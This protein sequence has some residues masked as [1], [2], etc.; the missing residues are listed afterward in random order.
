MNRPLSRPPDPVGSWPLGASTRLMFNLPMKSRLFSILAAVLVCG[1]TLYAG[2]RDTLWKQVD[3]AI[4]KGLPQTAIT[5]LN[6]ILPAALKAKAY[7][8]AAKA[9]LRRA[10]LEGT[11]QGNKPEEKITRLEAELV[12]APAEIQPLLASIQAHWYWHYFQQ[13]RWRFMNRTQTATAPG[14]D[15]TTWDLPR[16]FA[17]IDRQFQRSL[18]NAARLQAIPMTQFE[19]ILQKGT[20]P[21][22]YRPTLYDFL[23]H[24]AL[25]FYMAGEQA[26]A[27]PED[28][29]DFMADRPV[30]GVVRLF[31][32]EEEFLAGRIER[33]AG[34]SNP[35][36]ALFLFRDLL[37]F[38]ARDQDPTARAH[39]D[40]AR[41]RWAWN[42][43]TGD[44]KPDLYKAALKRFV[45]QWADH[46][47]AAEA[48]HDWARVLRGED[49]LVEA[50]RLAVRG[51]EAHPTSVGGRLCQNLVREIEA[52][53]LNVSTER[54]WNKPWPKITVQY[55]NLTNLHF[56]VVAFDWHLFL[57][58]NH[59]RPENLN[60]KDR[61]A[62]LAKAPVLEWSSPL[63]ATPDFQ[64]RTVELP[65]PEKLGAGFYFLLASAKPGF[66][67]ADN[68]VVCADFWVSELALVVRANSGQTEGFVL[69]AGSGEPVAGAE[70]VAWHLDNNG[71]R[72]KHEPVR[73]DELGLFKIPPTDRPRGLLLRARHQ[74]RELATRQEYASWNRG[75]RQSTRVHR[76][77]I[78]FTDRALYR[79]GQTVQYKGICI[80][81]QQSSDKYEVMPGA[82]LTVL[83]AD[84]NGKEIARQKHRANDYGSFSGSFTAPR[85]R[86]MGQMHLRIENGPPGSGHFRVE[87]YKRPKFQVT[88]EAPKTAPRLDDRVSVSGKA[89]AYT[90]AA[91]DGATVKWRVVREVRWPVWW[92]WWGG[93]YPWRG[94]E[95]QE[96]AHGTVKTATDGAFKVEFLARP[97][98]SISPTNEPTFQFTV[99]ADVTDPSGETRSADRSVRVGYTAL[100]ASVDAESWQLAGTPVKMA[101]RTTTLDGEGQQAEG[102]LK[103]HR[104]KEPASVVRPPLAGGSPVP[105]RGM[106]VQEG[107]RAVDLSDPNQWDLGEVA[108]EKGFNTDAEGRAE[109]QTPLA[110]G[111]YRVMLETQDRFGKKV[112]A[113]LPLRVL[114]PEEPKLS[115]KIPHLFEAPKWQ[116][117]PGEEFMAVWGTGY[118]DG[119]AFVEIEHRGKTIQRFWTQPGRTQQQVK[120]AVTEAMRG[121]FNVFV[122]QV[123][124][125][126][127]YLQTRRV[128][129]PWSNKNL[130]L[131]WEHFVSKLQPGQKETWSLS[132]RKPAV[133][134]RDQAAERAVAE[135]VAGLYDASL[136][137]FQKHRW[138]GG[139]SVFRH[140]QSWMTAQFE[141]Q[142]LGLQWIRGQWGPD[143]PGVEVTYRQFPP[144]LVMN[145]WGYGF[146]SKGMRAQSLNF[147]TRGAVLD[148][149]MPMPAA[150]APAPLMEAADAMAVE[151]TSRYGLAAR[152]K[153]GVAEIAG[154]A[155]AP[156][157][158]SGGA[159][160]GAGGAVNLAQVTARKNLNETAFFYP[161]VLSDSN[162]VVKLTFT[163]PEA[164]TTWR[165][166]AFAHD[167]EL[168]AGLIEADA[169][170]A[171]DL[172]VQ[173][174][175]PRFLREGDTLEFSVKVSNQSTNRQT[176]KV[177]LEL[178][179]A[180]NDAPADK[181]LKLAGLVSSGRTGATELDFDIPAKESRTFAWRLEVP[182]GCGFLAYKAVGATARMSDGEEGWL[183]VLSRRILVTESLPLPIRGKVG[184]GEVVKKFELEKL[185]KSGR[186]STLRHQSYT[187]QMVSQPAWYAVMALPCLMEFPHECSE[188][189][190]NRFYA[191]ALARH[192]ALK[193]PKI[194]RVFDQWKGTAALDS[195][196]EKNQDLKAVMLEETPWARQAQKEGEGRRNVGVLFDE[197]RLTHEQAGTLRKLVEMQ[198]GDGL[199][200]W[201]PGGRGNDY[202]TLYIVTGFG[203]LRHL[204]L[205][206]DVG[207]ALKALNRLDTWMEER[208]REIKK[209]TKP[210]DYV[211]GPTE[212]LFLY[213]RSFFLKD[214]ALAGG[215][216]EAV[217]FFRARAREHWLKVAN[218]Q[219]QGHL[220][221]ALDRFGSQAN[222]E[223][224]QA[225]VRSLKERSVRQ[226]EMGMF[227][228]ETELSWWWYR[229]PIETQAMMIEVFDEV[230]GDRDAVEECRVWLLKQ[231][232]T[233]D[234][235]TTKATADAVYALLLR[236]GNLL[237]S[238]K[239][240]EVKVGGINV[241]PG[242]ARTEG[243]TQPEA[244][245]G[246]YERRFGPGEIKP[247]MGEITVR[248]VDEGVSWG[249]VHWQY[250]EDMTKVTPYEGTPLKLKKALY[251]RVNTAKGPTLEPVKGALGVG[252]EL[253]VR[254]ELRVD[255]DMEYVH[256]KDQRGSGTEPVNVL[257]TYRYQDGL[258][259]YESTRDTASHFF[260]DYLP[261]GT[262]VF[263]YASRVQH[264][265]Q[266]QT[267]MASIQCMYAPEFNS[268]S[269][270]HALVVK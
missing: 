57:E 160:A 121:G 72:V 51:A 3:E 70:V 102:K 162:G 164:L 195:P 268:H 226:E 104:L 248:K 176:G 36:K 68:Q 123:R 147:R 165:L 31:G 111:L 2:G 18:T 240:V 6:E 167:K 60:D 30:A 148:G 201:F 204:G 64:E 10:M 38:H 52:R 114:K 251:R 85:D 205:D 119:R 100:E 170:T 135:L 62:V 152:A 255:R 220:A 139:F 84:V 55:R 22:R 169:V 58:K 161:Q 108:F 200:P 190:F 131:K 227:W 94:Q 237:A 202:I 225:I 56:R 193:D 269:E 196:L 230:A 175:P 270:S 124:E 65:A 90:G 25:S 233:Q 46:E 5:N 73:S 53:A 19:D 211:P 69:E 24:E 133:P 181:D 132:I 17:E 208:Y 186:S 144:D 96:I 8:E 221:L 77:T 82:D 99:H 243:S 26:A 140:D 173:P 93:R 232:Q 20:M 47:I 250:L 61:A 153:A 191:N 179:Y 14:K 118:A 136:D 1:M 219:N 15:F 245:T 86:L 16:L 247:A 81:F 142:Q 260:I 13:N 83:F 54:V 88:L 218:R 129:V 122:T 236:G 120:L 113:R 187:V 154:V 155:G 128:E 239:L 12:K 185:V 97:D 257:S 265:G 222:K 105:W 209:M 263:E 166:L 256:L 171:K 45:D 35:E 214:K 107:P 261:K 244:G 178:R 229:A 116:W 101:I 4:A 29:V 177:K 180:S 103:V 228:R 198:G 188:Q 264:R 74:G 217:D 182:D 199:W 158:G 141:N 213:G 207:A 59:G 258:A 7:G 216:K 87:E 28:A 9:M 71:N 231:K 224:A 194:R 157:P 76:Q 151:T 134:A 130:E 189:I 206:L 75:D 212:C 223:A 238:D 43:A 117:E 126:R 32:T 112:T 252:D 242:K 259:Y 33:R 137:Q 48:L 267:G 50:R 210:E 266:Y 66:D 41:L 203:R 146:P 92:G 234:W 156:V 21:D 110:V 23:A 80:E 249:S 246:F 192:I 67:E 11:I 40:L 91:V 95:S 127:A 174:N 63:S 253:V 254:I 37:R 159:D 215:P 172:M 241:T 42:V 34:E 150:V 197:N 125:N 79:P 89:E 49:Y 149:A 115:L 27:R 78:F 106:A 262:Y 184:G 145:W 44:T 183:P 109:I 235:K 143:L 39:A 138:P 168:R 163:M 98:R